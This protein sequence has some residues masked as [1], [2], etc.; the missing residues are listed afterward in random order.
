M[1]FGFSKVLKKN[2]RL[3]TS[4]FCFFLSVFIITMISITT[5]HK[6]ENSTLTTSYW[7]IYGLI[8]YSLH[9]IFLRLSKYNLYNLIVDIYSVD[10]TIMG[11]KIKEKVFVTS[12]VIFFCVTYISKVVVCC[13]FC[14][15]ENDCNMFYISGYLN[16]IIIMGMDVITLV[17]IFIYYYIY[18]AAKYL[19]VSLEDKDRHKDIQW[20]R[21]QFTAVADICDEIAPTY[22]RLV[23][24]S[25]VF[26]FLSSLVHVYKI[27]LGEFWYILLLYPLCTAPTY[28]KLT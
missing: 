22:G 19:K 17:Q 23:S 1:D 12:I 4:C 14:T 13:L 9:A 15:N 5:V 24:I 2:V 8:Q 11:N 3:L 10:L 27:K 21:K 28:L 26:C 20:V 6:I 18:K 25:L 16:C 7:L